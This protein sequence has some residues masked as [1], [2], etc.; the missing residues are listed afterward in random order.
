MT[1]KNTHPLEDYVKKL[2]CVFALTVGVAACNNG[3]KAPGNTLTNP[4][5]GTT[6]AANA[7]I[8]VETSGPAAAPAVPA[9]APAVA[10]YK[11]VTIPAGTTLRLSLQSGVASDTSRVEQPVRASLRSPVTIN[12]Q[13]ALPA[14]SEVTGVVTDAKESGRVQGRASVAFRFNS[15]H[16]NGETYN[17]QTST[18]SQ[19][20]PATKKKDAEKIGI[21]AGAGAALGA[22]LGGGKGAVKG[23]AIGGAG[24]TGVV[25]ATKGEEVRLGPGAA[26]TT[27]LTAPVT[28]R[29][30]L[31]AD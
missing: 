17:I 16:A 8:S 19:V 31:K 7:P 27:R 22:L 15:L 18:I 11:E 5:A 21:G 23:A 30:K 20:A 13:Q 2:A 10:Q 1:S 24:G 4:P 9:A 3:A 6:G 25:L 26:V 14:G 29:V 12:G 28:I